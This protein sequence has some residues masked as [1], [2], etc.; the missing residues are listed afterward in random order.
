MISIREKDVSREARERPI[1]SVLMLVTASSEVYTVKSAV[2]VQDPTSRPTS[3]KMRMLPGPQLGSGTEPLSHYFK[4]RCRA[5]M[6]ILFDRTIL[7]A[8]PSRQRAAAAVFC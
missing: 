5:R 7:R 4:Q 6:Q 2:N 3:S 1:A 8:S